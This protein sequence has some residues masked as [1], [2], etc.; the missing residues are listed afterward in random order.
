MAKLINTFLKAGVV[1]AG[2]MAGKQAAK[3]VGE[4][5]KPLKDTLKDA[6]K[7]VREGRNEDDL[8]GKGNEE[9]GY[10][11]R[12]RAEVKGQDEGELDSSGSDDE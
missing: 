8:D 4:R 3:F 5:L 12:H 1:S 11:N 7:S 10:F 6:V 2:W 9:E